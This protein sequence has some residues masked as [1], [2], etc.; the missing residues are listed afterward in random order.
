MQGPRGLKPIVGGYDVGGQ[1]PMA[2]VMNMTR[3]ARP[4]FAD[5]A[6]P[7]PY[8]E[9]GSD[10]A[11]VNALEQWLRILAADLDEL[12]RRL[13]ALEAAHQPR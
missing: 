8:A 1:A 6:E 5:V 12:S 3:M 11:R 7:V 9:P 10:A 2:V 4:S 13:S